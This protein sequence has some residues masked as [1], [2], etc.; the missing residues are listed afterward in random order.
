VSEPRR[1]RRR[2]LDLVQHLDHR[3]VLVEV[4]VQLD[5]DPHVQVLFTDEHGETHNVRYS[6]EQAWLFGH[7]VELFDRR[8]A[9]EIGQ[10]LVE[11]AHE[12]AR[13]TE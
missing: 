13:G 8:G 6:G 10:L 11:G 7:I 2:N 1:P 3:D 5:D 4:N 12:I 9:L